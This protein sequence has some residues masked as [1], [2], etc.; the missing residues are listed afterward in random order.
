[1]NDISELLAQA[2]SLM[3]LGMGLVFI[4]LSLLIGTITVIAWKFAP[5]KQPT[6]ESSVCVNRELQPGADTVAAI[7]VA[8]AHYRNRT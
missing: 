5:Q 3:L 6:I 2:G 4:F 7:T 1:M 8:I